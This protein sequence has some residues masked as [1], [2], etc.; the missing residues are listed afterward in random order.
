MQII[1]EITFNIATVE[2][3]YI[4]CDRIREGLNKYLGD[5]GQKLTNDKRGAPGYS[6]LV[7]PNTGDEEEESIEPANSLKIKRE[8]IDE[9]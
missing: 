6:M 8:S 4:I 3:E 7:T 9:S 5:N 1:V 2:N